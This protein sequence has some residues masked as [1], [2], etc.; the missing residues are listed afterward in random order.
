MSSQV[1]FCL[2]VVVLHCEAHK[3]QEQHSSEDKEEQNPGFPKIMTSWE[4]ALSGPAVHLEA[5]AGGAVV[6]DG[7]APYRRQQDQRWRAKPLLHPPRV[8]P[9]LPTC[10][11]SS[12][13]PEAPRPRYPLPFLLTASGSAESF[14]VVLEELGPMKPLPI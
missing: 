5:R 8:P 7:A 9:F 4:A 11:L 6:Q 3:T 10:R 12:G 2:K 1:T 14:P 13:A